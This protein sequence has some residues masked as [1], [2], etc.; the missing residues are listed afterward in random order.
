MA[1]H[2]IRLAYSGRVQCTEEVLLKEIKGSWKI[3][4][5]LW[6]NRGRQSTQLEV[7]EEVI[8]EN[9]LPF[10]NFSKL[11]QIMIGISSNTSPLERGSTHL[12]MICAKQ[13]NEIKCGKFGSAVFASSVKLPVTLP[14]QS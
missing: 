13:R 5:I 3:L 10:P 9:W 8:A 2:E 14:K 6:L 4:G 1:G 12:Q 11:L 7:I